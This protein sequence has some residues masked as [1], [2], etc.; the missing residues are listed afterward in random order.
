MATGLSFH[1]APAITRGSLDRLPARRPFKCAR[2]GVAVQ[3]SDAIVRLSFLLA[4][5]NHSDAVRQG[6]RGARR[7]GAPTSAVSTAS[8][9]ALRLPLPPSTRTTTLRLVSTRGKVHQLCGLSNRSNSCTTSS[10]PGCQLIAPC[11]LSTWPRKCFARPAPHR[12]PAVGS[13]RQS[14]PRLKR[15]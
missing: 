2:I 8:V 10:R 13:S 11:R 12:G 6:C 15:R 9:G 1:T 4:S 3:R 14:L 7:V 5:K